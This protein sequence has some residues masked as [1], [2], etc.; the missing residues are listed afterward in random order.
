MIMF[1]NRWFVF[2]GFDDRGTMRILATRNAAEAH[3]NNTQ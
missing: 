1:S 3:I 2:T